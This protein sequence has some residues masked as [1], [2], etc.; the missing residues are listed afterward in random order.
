MVAF[1]GTDG[2]GKSTI[3]ARVEEDLGDAFWMKKQYHKRPLS[4][5]FRWLRRYG[6]RPPGE[7]EWEKESGAEATGFTPHALPSRGAA[8]SLAKLTFWWVDF[9][10]LGYLAEFLPKLTSPNL[11]MFDRYYQDL[12]VDPRRYHYGGPMKLARLV[13]KLI[14]QP[15]LVIVLD[16]PPEVLL[17][18]KQELPIEEATRQREAYVEL[19]RT[20]PNG[21]VVDTSGTLDQAA[22]EAERIILDHMA[23][24]VARRIKSAGR[25]AKGA[26]S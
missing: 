5:P 20:L 19:A 8:Y 11:L 21:H 13:G 25:A 23:G 1:L 17:A 6:L 9:V 10:F 4:T 14:P 18:R 3:M 12:L 2:A 26:S 7:A 16:A 24:R 15:H 22:A